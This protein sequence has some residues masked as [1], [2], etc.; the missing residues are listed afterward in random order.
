MSQVETPKFRSIIRQVVIL[1]LTVL[2]VIMAI[3]VVSTIISYLNMEKQMIESNVNAMQ[4]SLNQLENQL[5]ALDNSFIQFVTKNR[6]FAYL[7]HMNRAA[8][9]DDYFLYQADTL[10]WLSNQLHYYKEMDGI[11]AYYSNMDL[12]MFRGINNGTKQVHDYIEGRLRTN[13]VMYNHWQIVDIG[14]RKYLLVINKYLDFY[15]GCWMSLEN[16]PKAYGLGSEN[17]LGSVYIVDGD[18]N[19]TIQNLQLNAT[20]KEYGVQVKR[21]KNEQYEY[22]NYY[23]SSSNQ[24]ISFAMLIPKSSVLNKVPLLNK[25]IFVIAILSFFLIPGVVYW[26]QTRIARPLKDVDVAMALIREGD[27]EYRLPITHKKHYDEFDLL[28]RKFNEMMEDINELEYNLYKTKIEEQRTELKYISQQIRPHFILNALNILYT[29]EAHEFPLVKKMVLYL[30]EYFQYIVNLK[31]DFVEVEQEFKHIDNYLKIQKERYP[32]RFEY[33]VQVND[34]VG[35]CLIPPLLIQTFVENCIKY[36]MK[37]NEKLQIVISAENR[38]GQLCLKI[39]DTGNGFSEQ[40]LERIYRFIETRTYQ[41]KLGVGIQN[42]IERLDILYDR[43]YDIHLNNG[44]VG[45]ASIE[46]IL[47]L[48][49]LY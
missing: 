31:V 35:G 39:V 7:S 14:E 4:I 47:P 38:E 1:P 28:F 33:S 15:C 40:A 24:D 2:L 32:E 16:L 17:L 18:F 41:E 10:E 3:M 13:N 42:A 26:L 27:M 48:E 49:A 22:R 6:S 11:F 8:K 23:V 29:Y 44:I 25:V 21:I 34:Q 36:A 5:D 9:T 37:D 12:L 45:G 46:L 30:S 20:I 43:K 19:N